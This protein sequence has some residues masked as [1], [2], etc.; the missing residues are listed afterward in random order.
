MLSQYNLENKNISQNKQIYMLKKQMHIIFNNGA[1]LNI[2]LSSRFHYKVNI[3][4]SQL[5]I[6]IGN[7]NI[8]DG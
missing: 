5:Y 8:L 7:F 1:Y 2:S 4:Y 3:N 6:T